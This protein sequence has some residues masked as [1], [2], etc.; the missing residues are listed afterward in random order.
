MLGAGQCGHDSGL[1]VIQLQLGWALGRAPQ[2]TGG[3]KE[4]WGSGYLFFAI[5]GGSPK[6]ASP[7]NLRQQPESGALATQLHRSRFCNCS[8]PSPVR[9]R[10]ADRAPMSLAL[11]NCTAPGV[12]YTL[13]KPCRIVSPCIKLSPS[14]QCE[15]LSVSWQTPYSAGNT[16]S[17]QRA[18]TLGSD[19][20]RTEFWL[21]RLLALDREHQLASLS[22]S[23]SSLT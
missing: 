10:G 11:G 4:P 22:L 16:V 12:S 21:C 17:A 15:L 2:E 18:R 1:F 23:R 5:P 20:T 14:Y 13:P 8:L 19:K 3:G 7:L 9:P 6:T